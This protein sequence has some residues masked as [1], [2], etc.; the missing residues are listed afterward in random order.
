MA[1]VAN[2]RVPALT[3]PW[4]LGIVTALMPFSCTRADFIRGAMLAAAGLALLLGAAGCGERAPTSPSARPP[5]GIP[6]DS[7][8]AVPAQTPAFS[9]TTFDG[10]SYTSEDLKGRPVILNFWADYCPACA[11]FAPRLEEVYQKHKEEGLLVF[12]IGADGSEGA[13]RK[14]ADALGIT[15][16]LAASTETVETFAVHAIPMTF[17]IGA[18]GETKSAILGARQPAQLAAEVEKIL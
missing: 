11:G 5:A 16:E 15:Y 9:F 12:G 8:S 7:A 6:S 3:R 14:K 18:D 4:R 1:F 17:L 13:L 10:K 2:R